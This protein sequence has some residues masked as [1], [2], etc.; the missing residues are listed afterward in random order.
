MKKENSGKLSHTI[1]ARIN[2]Q[3]YDELSFLLKSSKTKTMSNLVRRILHN[4]PIAV[5]TYDG[6]KDKL[7]RELAKI[8][9]ELNAIGVNINQVTREFHLQGGS[10]GKVFQA[11]EIAKQFQLTD[12]KV[13]ELFSLMAKIAESWSQG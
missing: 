11:L 13:T 9:S 12:Q 6:T 8:Q 4:Q 3:K 7:F 5:V 1:I 10:E 2:K